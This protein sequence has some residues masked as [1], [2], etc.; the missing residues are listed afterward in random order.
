MRRREFLYVMTGGVASAAYPAIPKLL[1]TALPRVKT[2]DKN[3]PNILFIAV[4]DLRT[5]LRCY[6]D[7]H[8]LTPNIDRLTEEG[9]VFSHAYCYDRPA[10]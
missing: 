6:G 8:A 4:D 3:M 10:A 9:V 5:Q 7:K 1:G 2:R